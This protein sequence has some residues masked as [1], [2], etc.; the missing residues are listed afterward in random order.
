MPSKTIA[1]YRD[2]IDNQGVA[3]VE[4]LTERRTEE[5]F[6]LSQTGS[7]LSDALFELSEVLV[8]N[9]GNSS[10]MSEGFV[11][12]SRAA[13]MGHVKAQHRLSIA[14]ATGLYGSGMVPMN[15][16]KAVLL[17]Y[18]AALGGS[19][20]AAM[21]MGN[22][23][24]YGI[25][26][27][28]NCESARNF[29]EFA[30]N[31]AAEQ[32]RTRGLPLHS[33]RVK[34]SE[35]EVPSTTG[36]KNIDAEAPDYY[37][38]LV[39]GD[40]DSAAAVTLGGMY[41][42][43]S[44]FVEQDQGKAIDYF[45]IA[46]T[47]G[48]PAASGQLGYLM[49]QQLAS[50][51]GNKRSGIK[52]DVSKTDRRGNL[53][54]A[55]ELHES[56]GDSPPS[57]L[58]VAAVKKMLRY[59][60][61][62]GDSNGH[63]GLGYLQY[64]GLSDVAEDSAQGKAKNHTMAFEIFYKLQ[65]KHADA[66]FYMGEI[67]M[68]R[69]QSVL[70]RPSLQGIYGPPSNGAKSRASSDRS[71]AY[72]GRGNDVPNLKEV[73]PVDITEDEVTID[74]DP[75]AA[76]RAYA[77]SSQRGNLLALHRISHMAAEGKGMAKSCSTAVSGFKAVA[78]RGDWGHDLT[79]A[80]RSLDAG[81]KKGALSLFSALA[82]IGVESAQFNAA[83]ILMKM[84]AADL[85]WIDIPTLAPEGGESARPEPLVSR[86]HPQQR[87][88][89][90]VEVEISESGDSS[91]FGK[92]SSDIVLDAIVASLEDG[93]HGQVLSAEE[94]AP[95]LP[96]AT[97][98]SD[99][100]LLIG[101]V[102]NTSGWLAQA[103]SKA[104]SEARALALYAVSASQTSA[105]SFL[106]VGDC[107]YY[108]CGGL[109]KDRREAAVFYQLAADLRNTHAI[110]NLGIMHEI[111]DGMQQD[112]H[113]AKR[114]YDMAATVDPDAVLP[115][116]VALMLLDGH[117][118]LQDWLGAAF[119]DETATVALRML[120]SAVERCKAVIRYIEITLP[121]VVKPFK[122]NRRTVVAPRSAFDRT[123]SSHGSS[124]SPRKG[125]RE[126]LAVLGLGFLFVLLHRWRKF[127]QQV[128]Q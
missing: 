21:G 3:D 96:T 71:H 80:H 36:R 79:K 104:N 125:M 102:S 124:A 9:Y 16:G 68:G 59:A 74:I 12:L 98:N 55:D 101:H 32:I 34:V 89:R 20:E 91:M 30:A 77:M 110:F 41:L 103:G 118:S 39:S 35:T 122:P 117:R 64:V 1:F 88:Q 8:S 105:E 5:V 116:A 127:R 46:A 24:L 72:F 84:N 23:Y 7:I 94:S 100:T 10:A 51:L 49:A 108:G 123:S 13:R 63:L 57:K 95:S 22:R 112:F 25:G 78:E 11:L 26:V 90:P 50:R 14:F 120:Q 62:R 75:V 52:S 99:M 76:V 38:H 107:F 44:R 40:G 43:G 28:E 97:P 121:S 114:F 86:Q 42:Q 85:T 81:D 6:A 18:M 29:Y 37:R 45:R 56:A 17:D 126:L 70:R 60:A 111:G 115:R 82:A 54:A 53:K 83:Y 33:E 69:S 67:L 19:P 31:A 93:Q 47:A 109:S 92:P 2:I 58:E 119:I 15:A 48:D 27:P 61:N 113:L 106:R 65:L 73:E 128:R 87:P 4:E 66:G